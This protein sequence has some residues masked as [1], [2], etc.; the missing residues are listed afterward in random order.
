QQRLCNFNHLLLGNRKLT[1]WSE[2]GYI[3]TQS[4]KASLGLGVNPFSIDQL[5][6]SGPDWLASEKNILGD[7]E[8]LEDR[9]PLLNKPEPLFNRFRYRSDHYVFAIKLN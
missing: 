7:V 9:Q 3:R 2:T 4:L 6:G 5:Q 8:I 1:G